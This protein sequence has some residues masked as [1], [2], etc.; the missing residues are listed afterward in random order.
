MTIIAI[1]S[2]LIFSSM[3]FAEEDTLKVLNDTAV[4]LFEQG[5]YGESAE[6]AE[7]ALKT[8]EETMGADSPKISPFLNNLAVIYYA[9]ERYPE[10]VALYERAVTITEK[11]LGPDHPRVKSMREGREKCQQKVAEQGIPEQPDISEHAEETDDLIPPAETGQVK[12]PEE[13]H[14]TAKEPVQTQPAIEEHMF[15]VQVGAFKDLL[16]AKGIQERLEKNGYDVSIV[17]VS[18]E[19]GEGLHKVQVGQFALRGKAAVRAREIKT[20]LGL[21]TYIT[22]K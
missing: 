12:P 1:S 3:V 21:D 16:N 11:A 15:T 20:L 6:L 18:A 4:S 5:K 13:T 19:D 8:A 17:T 22:V 10:A 7:R 2:L 14:E 9:Q